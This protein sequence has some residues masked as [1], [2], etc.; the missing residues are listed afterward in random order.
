MVLPR[1]L[2]V[3]TRSVAVGSGYPW[4]VASLQ[5][6][7]PFRRK[8]FVLRCGGRFVVGGEDGRLGFV[9]GIVTPVGLEEDGVDLL[10]T[11]VLVRSRTAS[12]SE[13]TQRFLTALRV[14]SE[15]RMMRLRACSVKV[16]WGRPT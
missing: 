13:P 2:F 9:L 11:T 5:S 15:V 10:E 14:P 8:I 12:M 7:R 1:R 4:L 3:T 16:W 6:Q